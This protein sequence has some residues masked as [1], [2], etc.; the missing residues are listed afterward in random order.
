MQNKELHDI[1][2]PLLG[3]SE[4]GETFEYILWAINQES[5]DIAI[6]NWLVKRA[7]LHS[8]EKV[9]LYI[10][11]FL[12]KQL[13]FK[14]RGFGSVMS[15]RSPIEANGVIYQISVDQLKSEYAHDEL[16]TSDKLTD[17]LMQLIKD[18]MILKQGIEVYIKHIIPYFSRIVDY[19]NKE[20][21]QIKKHVLLDVERHV[22]NNVALLKEI[23]QTLQNELTKSEEIPIYIDLEK[24]REIF[25]SE[26][27]KDL[28]N[29][30]FSKNDTFY[31]ENNYEFSMYINAIKNLETRLYSNYNEIVFL[32][33]KSLSF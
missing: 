4:N 1:K 26:I 32:Y 27:S 31:G 20:Y 17:L 13:H 11:Q 24:V 9:N 8:G 30:I 6:L 28:F 5:I 14:N 7:K 12:S 21:D 29:I 19:T 22:K 3:S 33:L 15:E 2:F 16:R 18:S 25:E 10:P 23:Y